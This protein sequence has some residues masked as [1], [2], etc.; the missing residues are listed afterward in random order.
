MKR[1]IAIVISCFIMLSIA[2]C[3]DFNSAYDDDA[4]IAKTGDSSS[5]RSASSTNIGNELSV[6]ATLTGTRTIWRYNTRD[7]VSIEL[8]YLLSVSSGGKA[9]LVLVTPDNEVIILSENT[10]NTII[11]DEMKSQTIS[12]KP[13]N[14]RIKIVGKDAPKLELKLHIEVGQL[15]W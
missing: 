10:D 3:G 8:S 6:T 1:I 7:E 2:G 13:G 15:S 14:N 4:T 9:K 11:N 12:L 5:M